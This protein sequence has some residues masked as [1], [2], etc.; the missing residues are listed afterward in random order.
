MSADE[1][2]HVATFDVLHGDEVVSFSFVEIED[3]GDVWMIERR[4]ESSFALEAFK[5]CFLGSE[6]RRENFDDDSAAEFC[7][8]RFVDSALSAYAEL[9]QNLI[10]AE[11][12][13]DHDV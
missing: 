11:G 6:L 5:V 4:G 3:G 9:L 7:I 12:F 8:G 1:L 2:S 10:T 13:A